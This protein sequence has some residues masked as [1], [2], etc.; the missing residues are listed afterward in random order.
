MLRSLLSFGVV[1]N[2]W[3]QKPGYCPAR[4]SPH[5][6]SPQGLR[7]RGTQT[8]ASASSLGHSRIQQMVNLSHHHRQ[9]MDVWGVG[10]HRHRTL[11]DWRRRAR[12]EHHGGAMGVLTSTAA[13]GV[14]PRAVARSGGRGAVGRRATAQLVEDRDTLHRAEQEQPTPGVRSGPQGASTGSRHPNDTVIST[15]RQRLPS[16]RRHRIKANGIFTR[17]PLHRGDRPRRRSR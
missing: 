15:E 11:R 17:L 1:I 9:I 12:W 14:T 5:K 7:N 4:T 8:P 10:N 16:P 13:R 3:G 6:G 2:L